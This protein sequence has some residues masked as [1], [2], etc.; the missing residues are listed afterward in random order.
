MTSWALSYSIYI[1][2]TKKTIHPSSVAE[3]LITSRARLAVLKLLLLNSGGR[4]YLREIA[5]RTGLAVRAV[6]LEVA[7]LE[8][9]GL[10][11][12]EAEGKRKYYRANRNASVL[13]E[14]QSLLLKTVGLGDLL[15][16]HFRRASGG[17]TVAFLYGSVA[18]G[19]DTTESDIDLMVVG[20]IGG[21]E[22]SRLLSPARQS[23]G[24]EINPVIMTEP[25]FKKKVA[26]ESHFLRSV[27]SER[28]IFLVGG[29]DDIAR[30]AEPGP[31]AATQDKP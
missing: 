7:R 30:L 31:A 8:A 6:Q 11:V 18:R 16:E 27:L 20:S 10:L 26:Q 21:R 5:E 22:L 23:L 15:K 29:S 17:I 28:K 13:P 24:R 4:F 19:E 2:M 9:S 1:Q 3:S 12:S 14:L 25:E